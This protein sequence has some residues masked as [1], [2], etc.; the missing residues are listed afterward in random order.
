MTIFSHLLHRYSKKWPSVEVHEKQKH[1]SS[2]I[3]ISN[4]THTHTDMINS[5]TL[6]WWSSDLKVEQ[7]CGACRIDQE[8]PK[9]VLWNKSNRHRS[10][11]R[12]LIRNHTKPSPLSDLALWSVRMVYQFLVEIGAWITRHRNRRVSL[13]EASAKRAKKRRSGGFGKVPQAAWTS[14]NAAEKLDDGA[15]MGLRDQVGCWGGGGGDLSGVGGMG[16]IWLPVPCFPRPRPGLRG[17]SGAFVPWTWSGIVHECWSRC[18]TLPWPH[19]H[20]R[21]FESL[22]CTYSVV[23]V[24]SSGAVLCYHECK[25]S[26]RLDPG[27][28]FEFGSEEWWALVG[29]YG[30]FWLLR[31]C[32]L[33]NCVI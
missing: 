32:E 2:C 31:A 5:T 8:W 6:N 17:R 27:L 7:P 11:R 18:W 29:S 13:P 9:P 21:P 19:P 33:V 20:L 28:W 23:R 14:A 1:A 10:L 30:F 12:D 3:F 24:W 22:V 25:I 26:T 15:E 16:W 4:N